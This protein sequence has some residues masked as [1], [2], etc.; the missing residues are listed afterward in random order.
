MIQDEISFR[1]SRIPFN[2]IPPFRDCGCG[3][4]YKNGPRLDQMSFVLVG[5]SEDF[6]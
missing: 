5:R 3:L 6:W 2:V 4:I 1:T